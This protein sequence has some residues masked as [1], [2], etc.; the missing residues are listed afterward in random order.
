MIR[1][2]PELVALMRALGQHLAALREAAEIVQQQ[3]AHRTG[4]SRSSVAKAE[5][6]R[7][8]LTRDF[9]KTADELLQ[10]DGV[11]LASYEQVR[12][13][14][15]AQGDRIYDQLTQFLRQCAGKMDRR[16]LSSYSALG[17]RPLSRWPP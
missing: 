17:L 14:K 15:Q 3:I 4:Y 8:L 11:L 1:D 2:P 5:A 13:A 12:A 16:E 6:G 9:W 10:A 7:Q